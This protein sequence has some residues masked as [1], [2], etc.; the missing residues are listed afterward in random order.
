MSNVD[1][2]LAIGSGLVLVL[3]LFS[4][5]IKRFWLSEPMLAMAVGILLGLV[6]PTFLDYSAETIREDYLELGARLTLAVGVM[7]AALRLPKRYFARH[8]GR[9]LVLLGLI[10]PIMWLSSTGLL[11]AVM[12]WPFW[13]ALLAGAIITPTDPVLASSIVTGRIAEKYLPQSVREALTAESGANDGLA[14]PFVFFALLFVANE[15]SG[16]GM[17]VSLARII[18]WEVGFAVLVGGIL[19]YAAGK[20]LDWAESK[21]SI[22]GTSFLAYTVALSLLVLG[23]C[24]LLGSSGIL[25]VFVSGIMFA[26]VVPTP[27]R[28]DEERVQEAVNR[29]LLLPVFLLFGFTLPLD[30]WGDVGWLCVA[31]VAGI[32]LLRRLPGML[33]VRPLLGSLKEWPTSLS[34]GW[35]GPIGVAAMFYAMAAQRIAPSADIW[36]AVSLVIFSSVI[37][38]GLTATPLATLYGRWQKSSSAT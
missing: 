32:L 25:G 26:R 2:A 24:G 5:T 21:R 19:G 18:F 17:A 4:D 15:A 36:P 9:M 6:L 11:L 34:L 23:V 33:A 29:F 1:L 35:F 20:L 31:L 14:Y 27:E 28:R 13:T 7:A 37:V 12:G 10:M 16:A 8:K 30:D 3:G 38:H 22:E